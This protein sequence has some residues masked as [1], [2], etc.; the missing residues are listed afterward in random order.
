MSG[1]CRQG[2][3]KPC[4]YILFPL[5]YEMYRQGS[6]IRRMM[7][8][9][10]PWRKSLR[11]RLWSDPLRPPTSPALLRCPGLYVYPAVGA[12]TREVMEVP[13]SYARL[14]IYEAEVAR[15]WFDLPPGVLLPLSD[16]NS[17][18]L[19]FHGHPGSAAGP[20]VL[21]AVLLFPG[22][23]VSCVGAIEFHVRASDWYAHQ[24]HS[25]ARY[26]QVIL[27]VVLIC[28]HPSP[29]LCQDGRAIPMCSLNDLAQPRKSYLTSAWSC[30][31]VMRQL[32][33]QERGRLLR[34]AGL[35]RFEQKTHAFVEL[36][37]K[38]YPQDP[39]QD[40]SQDPVQDSQQ[41][42]FSACDLCLITALAEGLGYGRDR[43]FFRAAGQHLLG[44]G[45]D[46]PEPL[47]RTMDPPPLDKGRLRVLRRLVEQWRVRSA[48][49]TLREIVSVKDAS[50]SLDR[51]RAVFYGLG[52]A[53]AD[54]LICNV[55]LPFAMAVA[56]IEQD[57]GLAERAQTLYTEHPGLS[58]NRI[59]R[60]MCEQLQ[61]N[62]E[63]GGACEQQGLHYIYQ[64]TCREKR[65]ELCMVGERK[66]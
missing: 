8:A 23:A 48:W 51:L 41:S 1:T 44:L 22:H 45:R 10:L 15:R 57:S 20:D 16:G 17:C 13:S 50:D 49:Q 2:R 38:S 21:D 26:T 42:P 32:D 66:L 39:S 61:L 3:G 37:H 62:K 14:H 30:Q 31:Q 59:T 47:G 36:L 55:V 65:C 19:L 63:P 6:R 58:S 4:P 27:H 46:L 35:L 43:A 5:P 18:Q 29:A 9:P 12:N 54:I 56:L 7:K 60:A 64:Q 25:D 24:H 40:P 52:T 33:E 34:Q 53:R 28:D 11:S